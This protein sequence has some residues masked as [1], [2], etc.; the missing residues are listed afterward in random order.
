M[1]RRPATPGNKRRGNAGMR[2]RV[3]VAT[4]Q[5]QDI[6]M[7]IR[8]SRIALVMVLTAPAAIAVAQP[9][10][11]QG[12]CPSGYHTSGGY[13]VPSSGSAR[14]ALPKIGACPSGYHTSGDYCLGS[15]PAAKPAVEKRGACPSGYHTSGAYCLA[16]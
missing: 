12:A 9:V 16:N 13:C 8:L 10:P 11:K 15:S 2:P 14:P 3:D 7:Q 5:A 1:L 6:R 4:V